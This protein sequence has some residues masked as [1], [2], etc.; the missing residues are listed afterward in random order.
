MSYLNSPRLTFSGLFQA[1]PS[2]VNNDPTHFNNETFKPSFQ[3][4]QEGKNANGW[5]NPEGTGNW[6]FL[7]C[8][9]KSVTYRDGT[10]TTNEADDPV[11]SMSIMD[12]GTKVAGKIVDLDT[13]QQMVSA[14]WGLVVRLVSGEKE[15]LKADYEVASFTNIWMSRA[16]ALSGDTTAAAIYQSVLKNIH[17]DIDNSDSRFLKELYLLGRYQLSIQFTVDLYD[18]DH[19]SP[20][21]TIGRITGSIA[22]QYSEPS[23]FTIGRPLFP[24]TSKVNYANAIVDLEQS[25]IVLDL[26]NSFP[27]NPDGNLLNNSNL[28]LAVLDSSD[29]N[30]TIEIGVIDFQDPGWY[31]VK[32]GIM[33]FPLA[34]KLELV[35]NNPLI[36]LDQNNNVLLEESVE[37]VCADKFVFYLNPGESC[38]VE[39]YA[40]SLGKPLGNRT[41]ELQ[42]NASQFG[43]T[44]PQVGWPESALSFPERVTLD[45]AGKAK[46]TITASDPG[47]PRG[48]ID[49]QVYGIAYNLSTDLFSNCN[50]SNFISILVF[51]KVP[52]DKIA[53]PTWDDIQPIMQQYANLYPLMSK[54]IFNLA[55]KEVV[56]ANAEI[57]KFVFSKDKTDPNYM[58]A[59]RDLSRDKS[60]MILNYLNSVLNQAAPNDSVTFKKL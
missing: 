8:E 15:I 28:S 13:Q 40:T 47:N 38:E 23:F 26:A 25:A 45:D 22:P 43:P 48:Y 42:L 21:F 17:W 16:P 34:D 56:D 57:L 24:Q 1:D 29:N 2:T 35:E 52:E 7:N 12:S 5:W 50:P 54:G 41:I 14:L 10:S 37:Y 49:G 30:K 33:S 9:V 11:L 27:V 46:V 6:R 59:T 36:I 44:P 53:N 3:K 51:D 60:A 31:S 20:Q 19:T 18:M 55:D 58:P 39:F 4:M 32:S